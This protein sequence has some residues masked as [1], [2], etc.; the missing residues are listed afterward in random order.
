MKFGSHPINLECK[1]R[2]QNISGFPI[3]ISPV[4][5]SYQYTQRPQDLA[6]FSSS[7]LSKL[8]RRHQIVLVGRDQ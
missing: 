7:C 1:I 4:S 8:V 5:Y 6:N 3:R 2:P